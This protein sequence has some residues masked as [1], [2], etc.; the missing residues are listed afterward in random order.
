MLHIA[1]HAFGKIT[2]FF[3][4]G[5]IQVSTGFKKVS[6]LAGLGRRMPWT[7]GAFLVGSLSV[8]GLPPG[9][10]FL[11]KWFLLLGALESGQLV[12]LIVLLV[13]SFLNAAY[14]LPIVYRA[15]FEPP[16][17]P[18]RTRNEGP[19]WCLGPI[20]FTAGASVLL[21]LIPQPFIAL[22]RL[23]VRQVMGTG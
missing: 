23:A 21:L 2:L 5:A 4:A 18:Y 19:R 12:F 7:L 8:I 6:Q 20:L 14:F 3:C 1:M 10:G 11:S 9:G 22:A 13:S 15:F 17:R 16:P